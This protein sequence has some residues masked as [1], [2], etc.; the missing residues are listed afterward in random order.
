MN[1][2]KPIFQ[3]A[4]LVAG[5]VA[6]VIVAGCASCGTCQGAEMPPT[7]SA[8]AP[9]EDATPPMPR[10]RAVAK[11]SNDFATPPTDGEDPTTPAPAPTTPT[12][13]TPPATP[14]RVKTSKTRDVEGA[15][16]VID[17]S[18]NGTIAINSTAPA[19]PAS[20]VPTVATTAPAYPILPVPIPDAQ[21]VGIFKRVGGG[22]YYA[23]TGKCPTS[24]ASAP[25]AASAVIP[26]GT[27][28]V[29]L[30]HYATVPVQTVPV[31]TVPVQTVQAP[32]VG[33]YP[34]PA[35]P[36]LYTAQLPP[37][38]P[39]LYAL[40]AA[41]PQPSPQSAAMAPD[42]AAPRKSFLSRICNK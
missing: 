39:M 41:A 24:K 25:A 35:A 18:G 26:V 32:Q 20:V 29:Q 16:I 33:Y 6:C 1:S 40:P 27:S 37:P 23:V 4:L 22:L 42:P 14:P 3:Y 7:P 11:P 31:Q 9:A 2:L 34:A 30:A 19:L 17:Q 5:L 28:T 8:Q 15:A 36:Q 12:T 38:S 10:W 13:P 21:A